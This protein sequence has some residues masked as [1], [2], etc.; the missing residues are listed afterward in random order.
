MLFPQESTLPVKLVHVNLLQ[1]GAC[2]LCQGQL[3]KDL[4]FLKIA[5]GFFFHLVWGFVW[6]VSFLF[7]LF[8]PWFVI[9]K[10]MQARVPA[11]QSIDCFCLQRGCCQVAARVE[12]GIDSEL[13]AS[14]SCCAR[15]RH[16]LPLTAAK[17]AGEA[18]HKDLTTA[19]RSISMQT[20]QREPWVRHARTPS[21]AAQLRQGV[22]GVGR[23]QEGASRSEGCPLRL[24]LAPASSGA[25]V[26][27]SGASL[28][29][30]WG[31]QPEQ[32]QVCPFVGHC[33]EEPP[34]IPGQAPGQPRGAV[35]RVCLC[36]RLVPPS[37]GEPVL[38]SPGDLE[39][40]PGKESEVW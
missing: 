38:H 27:L 17:G 39:D 15:S 2:K 19:R 6:F 31:C 30:T 13:L 40:A 1:Q 24:S 32:E 23:R 22:Q 16:A 5:R 34:A 18:P 37:T 26:W 14:S 9:Q 25:P 10:G 20:G 29:G 7:F 21:Q 35:V 3:E 11:T 4:I 12:P 8:L 36:P 28:L 33:A